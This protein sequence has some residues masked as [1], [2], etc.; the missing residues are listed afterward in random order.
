M[1]R[2]YSSAMGAF[3]PILFFVIVYAV[4]LFLAFFVCR[5]V[6]YAVHDGDTARGSTESVR[7]A[8]PPASSGVAIAYNK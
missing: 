5:T 7:P 2:N 8:A 1:N 3:H 4:S 6:Y